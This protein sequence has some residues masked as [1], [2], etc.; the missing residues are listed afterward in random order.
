[1][2]YFFLV[3]FNYF[4]INWLIVFHFGWVLDE[5]KIATIIK[6]VIDEKVLRKLG[7]VLDT[8]F[9]ACEKKMPRFWF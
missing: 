4:R 8:G 1:M 6:Q 2:F 7:I 5:G 9:G 3:L